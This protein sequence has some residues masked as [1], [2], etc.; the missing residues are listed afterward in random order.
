MS[1]ESLKIVLKRICEL[2]P[3][4]SSEN[5]P[6]MQERGEL[7]R[8]SLTAEIRARSDFIIRKMDTF[9]DRFNVGTTDRTSPAFWP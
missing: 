1:Q 2:Q 4:Y 8:R 7:I 9:A 6:A 5:T 3:N